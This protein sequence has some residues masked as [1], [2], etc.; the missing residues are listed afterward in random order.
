MNI[1]QE[2]LKAFHQ[3]PN[4]FISGESLSQKCQCT[5]TA[6]WKY[7]EELRQEG[8]QFEAV[9][10]L[11]YRL[12]SSPDLISAEEIV[13]GIETRV[14]GTQVLAYET[15]VSTQLLAH[16]VAGKG[17]PEGTIVIAE[18]QT[19]GKGRLGRVWH[20]PKG[21][22]I[23][24]S[25]II[26]PEIPLP[27]APQMTLLTAVAMAKTIQ[28]HVGLNVQIKWPNDVFV[29]GKKV[30]G[31]LTELNAESDRIN[32]LVIGIGINVNTT[33]ED[34][35]PELAT[36]GTSLRIE[37][38]HEIRRSLFV[39][40]FCREF[41]KLYDDYLAHGFSRIKTEW[42]ANSLSLG[43]QVTV[44]TLQ[45]TIEGKAI[46]LDSEGVLLVEDSL[47]HLHNVY[48]ADIEYRAN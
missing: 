10:K 5:R 15:V 45:Q 27:K 39:Q 32:Y 12:L 24:M 18:Q 4:E 8:Y 1:K 11:G 21:S 38:G 23:W 25:L 9:R 40:A 48:S 30:C 36:V 37:A 2:I 3:T 7:I 47:G 42:E 44:R 19:G 41:E 13:S 16:E 35:P 26:R 17:A 31:I 34:F 22:G 29:S 6:V 20:S 46:G 28:Q 43:R 33:I 14:I